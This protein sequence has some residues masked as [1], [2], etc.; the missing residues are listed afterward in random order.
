[1]SNQTKTLDAALAYSRRGWHVFPLHN[2][3]I[4]GCSCS[5][6]TC[7]SPG[8]HPRTTHGLL[9]ATTDEEQIRSWLVKWPD[10]NVG[11]L[12]GPPSGLLVVDID[13]EEGEKA[14]AS[15]T[16]K[17]SEISTLTVKT[18]R[19][20]HLYFEH[21]E[22]ALKNSTSKVGDHIDVRAERGY[23]VAAPSLHT[24][25]TRYEIADAEKELAKVPDWL[26]TKMATK[27]IKRKED[28]MQDME[29]NAFNDAL[30][31]C[32]GTR[33]DELYKLGSALRGQHGMEQSEIAPIL[34]EYNQEKC[35]PPIGEIEV[36][37]IT[38][39]VC[40][41]PA[42]FEASK[43]DKRRGESPLYWFKFNLREFFADQNLMLMTD[44][45]T[46]WYLRLK[47]LAWQKGGFL[48]SDKKKLWRFAKAKSQIAF[49]R[50]CDLVLEEY[51]R[52]TEGGIK[53]L[54]NPVMAAHY[55][56]VLESWMQKKAGGGASRA[57][58]LRKSTPGGRSESIQ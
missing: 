55:A 15:L 58:Y 10:A 56:D 44:Y 11:I 4:G 8:K 7:D 9:D 28:K 49:E 32:E 6:T 23:V 25:G 46:G 2:P 50:D 38:A 41:H 3:T 1:M 43:S 21:P 35:I 26:L 36:M 57:A 42:E 18:G 24:N 19:G 27:S 45:Q 29:R 37:Q 5:K 40:K 13:G 51:D 31:I 16:S 52:V 34:R 53:M 22:I 20:R 33:N 14:F 47:A 12:T 30:P 17:H 39:N 54:K 48:T